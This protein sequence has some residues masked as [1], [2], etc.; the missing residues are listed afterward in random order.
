MMPADS[1]YLI[2]GRYRLGNV[3]GRGGM[4]V[5]R[6]A[7]DERLARPVAVKLLNPALAN[8]PQVRER[9]RAEAR[10]A[11]RLQHPHAVTVFDWGEHEGEP[12]LVMELL[13]GSTLADAMRKGRLPL[14]QAVA[15]MTDL[16]SAVAAAHAQGLV[17]RDIKAANVLFTA[18]GVPKLAD[19]GIAKSMG[20]DEQTAT[21]EVLGTVA[22]M[23]PERLA[24]S[25]A[26]ITTDLWAL[27]VLLHEMVAGARPFTG[28][29]PA[30]L[31]MAIHGNDRQPVASVAPG[32]PPDLAAV[33]EKA[34]ASDPAERFAD[35]G[36]LRAA[37]LAAD[38]GD[39]EPAAGAVPP[40]AGLPV[41]TARV[42]AATAAAA[43]LAAEAGRAP[44]KSGLRGRT[45]TGTRG[46]A[47]GTGPEG[48]RPRLAGRAMWATMAA[49]MV[50]LAEAFAALATREGT[51]PANGTPQTAAGSEIPTIPTTLAPTTTAPPPTTAAPKPAPTTAPKPAPTTAP[52]T[53]APPATA[54]PTTQPAPTRSGLPSLGNVDWR[55]GRW[56]GQDRAFGNGWERA[57]SPQW[58]R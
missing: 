21:G 24:G 25:P 57:F 30:A 54:P 7:Y 15:V 19:F 29:H 10:S 45:A 32:L 40:L 39:G 14:P 31:M 16:L 3:L 43:G 27:G 20:D 52:P 49:T 48:R 1:T 51:P 55:G 53:T 44:Q 8:R 33:V 36:M 13:P 28:E 9:F 26:D 12:F 4:G 41:T 35:A 18:D 23:A 37:L 22:Y 2:S 42:P 6:E 47:A 11:A 50:V 56:P 46:A 58:N 38:L 17:H 5:V 34:L